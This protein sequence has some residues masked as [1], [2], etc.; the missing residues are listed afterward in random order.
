MKSPIVDQNP[1][2][3]TNVQNIKSL[4]PFQK[5]KPNF[6]PNSN[7]LSINDSNSTN[8]TTNT[9]SPEKNE[10]ICDERLIY[11]N[12]SEMDDNEMG[13]IVKLINYKKIAFVD[14]SN[15]QL[16]KFPLE[17]LK[18]TRKIRRLSV[19]NN[20][21]RSLPFELLNWFKFI[22]YLDVSENC[23][24]KIESGVFN[25]SQSSPLKDLNLSK[26]FVKKLP[27]G[28]S[29]L[30]SLRTLNVDSND[31]EGIPVVFNKLLKLEVLQLS[32]SFY[33]IRITI[34]N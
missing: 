29:C 22:E 3:S 33:I 15:N 13:R 23:I 18:F 2:V 34:L 7:N 20:R 4:N 1:S 19:P 5:K 26:N 9:L 25:T 16:T 27:K 6:A 21:I 17:I 30:S 12:K 10:L 8:T 31:L 14:L 32:W 24:E 28:I 11:R